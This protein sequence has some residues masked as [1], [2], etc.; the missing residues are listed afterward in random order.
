LIVFVIPFCLGFIKQKISEN[1]TVLKC[2]RDAPELNPKSEQAIQI[3]K[4]NIKQ[5][6]NCFDI[7]PATASKEMKLKLVLTVLPFKSEMKL[8]T[9]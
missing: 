2:L 3:V 4:E 5:T 9:L 8:N 6:K 7:Q 1:L